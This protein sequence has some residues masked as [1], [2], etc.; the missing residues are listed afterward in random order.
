MS[1]FHPRRGRNWYS[2]M[3]FMFII[4]G[5]IVI[6]RDIILWSP[7]FVWDFLLNSDITSEK[8][9]AGMFMFGGVL[10]LLGYRKKNV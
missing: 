8:V 7:E 9:S 10:V 3:G 6:V 4:V 1:E 5:A 2:A